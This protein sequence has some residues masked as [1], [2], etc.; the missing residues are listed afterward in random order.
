MP[1][2]EGSLHSLGM[3]NYNPISK[4]MAQ[5]VATLHE[6]EKVSRV[7]ELLTQ[8]AHNGFPVISRDGKLRGLILRKTLCGLLKQKAFSTPSVGDSR[9]SD[10]GIK[11]DNAATIF[12]DQLE[13]GY[14]NYPDAKSIK[15]NE[16]EFVSSF[17]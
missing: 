5:P 12:Y 2:L 17:L 15:L 3:L 14:P 8:T 6:I 16:K 7:V 9:A 10:G 11:L 13:R 4:I 1:F